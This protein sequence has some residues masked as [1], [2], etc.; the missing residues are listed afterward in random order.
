MTI[1][2]QYKLKSNNYYLKY[3]RSHS[4]WYKYLNRN[5]IFFKNFENEVKSYYKLTKIDKFSKTLNT[6]EMATKLLGSMNDI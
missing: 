2:I 3:L 6:I 1:D 5:P 4:V